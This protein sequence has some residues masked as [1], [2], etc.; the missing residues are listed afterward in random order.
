MSSSRSATVLGLYVEDFDK[1]DL[2]GSLEDVVIL[3]RPAC[4]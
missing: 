3:V 1:F 2:E 4:G